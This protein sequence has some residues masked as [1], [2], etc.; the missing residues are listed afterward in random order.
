M[1]RALAERA[2]QS[3]DVS[4][5]TNSTSD[6]LQTSSAADTS[7]DISQSSPILKIRKLDLPIPVKPIEESPPILKTNDA[8]S[9]ITQP[10]LTS[11]TVFEV[12]HFSPLEAPPATASNKQH[13]ST[14]VTSVPR[15]S[16]S[17]APPAPAPA[18]ATPTNTT[19]ASSR[20]RQR[21]VDNANR[22]VE[23]ESSAFYLKHQNKALAT[24]LKS[25]QQSLRLLEE[26]RDYRRKQ[27]HQAVQALHNLQATWTQLETALSATTSLSST[28]PTAGAVSLHSMGAASPA[29]PISLPSDAPISTAS[30]LRPFADVND[31]GLDNDT[32]M[33]ENGGAHSSTAVEW[34]AALNQALAS[35]GTTTSKLQPIKAASVSIEEPQQ[36]CLDDLATISVNVSSRAAILQQCIWPLLLSS[37]SPS[38]TTENLER[39]RWAKELSIAESECQMLQIQIAEITRARDEI[40][41]RER[42]NRR[43]VYRLAA[44]MLTIDQLAKACDDDTD[45][46]AAQV[47]LEAQELA[48]KLETSVSGNGNTDMVSLAALEA[49]KA[50]II[51]LENMLNNRDASIQEVSAIHTHH[52]HNEY[53]RV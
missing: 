20:K 29:L 47:K 9:V 5:N 41:T 21:Q 45:D 35:L 22:G 37:S 19:S 8:D 2:K 26:E 32:Q 36:H 3:L 6:A 10:P 18:S 25:V 4:T 27:C 15:A 42:R 44:G 23:D 33:D 46:I 53:E 28:S 24:E 40:A 1:K 48:P 50:R 52:T 17:T 11:S 31:D 39:A 30:L 38:S 14:Q 43:N 51:D 13:A 34:T 7:A 16:I 12:K 49:A